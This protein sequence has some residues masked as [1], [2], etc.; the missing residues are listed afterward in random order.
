ML[1]R[2]SLILLAFGFG[3]CAGRAPHPS[4]PAR[5]AAQSRAGPAEA[6]R[7]LI[8][9]DVTLISP[10][11]TDPLPH[12]DVRI[13]RGRIERIGPALI[14]EAEARLIEGRGKYLVPGLI[15]SHVHVGHQGPLDDALIEAHPDLL[16]AWRARIGR[17]FLAFGF[18]TLVDLDLGAGTRAWFD[19]AP[20]HP[21]L[22]DCGR[23]I[24]IPGGYGGAQSVPQDEAGARNLN[25]LF[26][27]GQSDLWPAAVE[28]DDFTPQKIVERVA[29][30]GA[31]CL[32]TFVEPGF[33]GGAHWPVPRPETLA[34]LRTETR[35]LGLTFVVH[36]NAVESWRAAID[37]GAD[38]IAH[39][40]WHWPGDRMS[41]EP[42]PAAA[43]VIEAAARARIRVQPTLQAVYG[44]E[45]I[46]D[47]SI[48]EDPR[49]AE[50][51]PGAV[52]ESL[53]GPEARAARR[54]LED[55]YRG[56]IERLLGPEDPA[57]VMA[58]APARAARTLRM[59]SDRSVPLLFGSD[60]PSNEGIGNPPGLNGRWEMR[61]WFEAGVPLPILLRAATIDNAA[62]FGL[63]REVGSIEP[64]KRADLLILGA[65]PLATID[66][67]D[68]IET[69]ILDG[70]PIARA[71]LLPDR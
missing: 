55:E 47:D 2:I 38:V 56:A 35:R 64:G 10:E 23:A 60:T 25:L 33:G 52:L 50:A 7:P 1:P 66:A 16:R 24:R 39:G 13:R 21:R 48:L 17:S 9:R 71:S 5:T 68:T 11:R 51:I 14:T 46:F 4:E 58:V 37:A 45:S 8:I 41:P 20:L 30:G 70:E 44:D 28:P 43:A 42:P 12:V 54:A 19:A 69:V 27:P 59:M 6:G 57:R 3:A 63:A 29:A 32:K 49:L 62:A 18:T 22:H 65:D 40:L 34:A 53:R 15:D 26:E 67:W 61:R 31:I 36:A